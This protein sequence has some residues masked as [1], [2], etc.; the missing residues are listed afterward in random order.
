[1]GTLQNLIGKVVQGK[2]WNTKRVPKPLAKAGAWVQDMFGNPFIKP[3]VVDLADDHYEVDITQARELL[4]WEPEHSLRNTIPKMITFLK[5]DPKGFY[6]E[7]DL[8][9]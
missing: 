2:E 1:M 5:G 6:R 4:G 9:K 7:N 3:W 8:K